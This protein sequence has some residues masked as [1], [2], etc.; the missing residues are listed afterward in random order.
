MRGRNEAS[1]KTEPRATKA[2]H[3]GTAEARRL[4]GREGYTYEADSSPS[5]FR[6]CIERN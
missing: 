4:D 1:E 6:Y 3:P 2:D 5:A